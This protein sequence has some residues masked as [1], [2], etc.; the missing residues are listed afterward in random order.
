MS[1]RFTAAPRRYRPELQGLRAIAVV[2]VVVYHVWFGRISGGVDVFFLISGFLLTGQLVRAR[3]RGRI[4]FAAFWGKVAKR[5]LPAA[6]TVLLAV[7]AASVLL[8]P[9]HRWFQTIREVF[10]SAVFLEN[11]RLAADSADYFTQHDQS[12]VVQHFWSLSIQGQFYLLWPLLIALVARRFL[13]GTLIAVFAG[14]LAFSVVLTAIDQ[15]LAYFHSLTRVWEFALGGLLAL[16]ID[17]VALPALVRVLLGWLGIAG[18]ISCG[19]VLTVGEQFPGYAALW[20]LLSAMAVLLAGASGSPFGADRILSAR[21]MRYLGDL[22]YSLYLWHWPILVFYLIARER[23][24]IGL[25]GGAGIIGLSVV[26]AVLTHH[27]IEDPAR[28]VRVRAH[29]FAAIAL[30]PVLL[31][32]GGWQVAARWKADAY[33][34]AAGSPDHPGARALTPGFEY[35]GAPDPP[36][37]PAFLSLPEEYA[38]TGDCTVAERHAELSICTTGAGDPPSKRI[39]VA[40]DSHAQQFIAALRP[41]AERKNWQLISMLRGGC[42]FSTDSDSVPGDQPCID[43]N[44]AVADEI[45]AI[46]P[47]AVFTIGTRDARVGMVEHTPPGYVSQWRKVA[48]AGIPVLAARDNPRYDFAPSACVDANGPKAPECSTPRADL[49]APEPPYLGIDVPPE[50]SFL[51]FS[52]YFCERDLCPPVIGNVL[53]YLDDNHVTSTYMTTMAPMVEEAV[54]TAL[55]W[56]TEDAPS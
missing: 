16:F 31:A 47:D 48:A 30:V 18:L 43:W 29:R 23:T 1:E 26:L 55:G 40:G 13:T 35:W 3:E 45:V 32:A 24:E 41:V 37:V 53:L 50:V 6:L 12:S 2:L 17:K 19:L 36:L 39:V 25:V 14:S 38:D 33:A 11:W 46:A 15:P 21:P 51:D 5:L 4:G 20:P 56:R 22:S 44:A 34:L 49:F 28:Q 9:E 7:I 10:A 27:F 54:E 52:D 42:P 8:L